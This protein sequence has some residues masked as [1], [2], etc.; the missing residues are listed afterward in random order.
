MLKIYSMPKKDLSIYKSSSS[1]TTLTKPRPMILKS[2]IKN[3]WQ[4]ITMI[5]FYKTITI[6]INQS[7]NYK[8]KT[9]R[10]FS[11]LNL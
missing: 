3:Q 7:T 6:L 2:K 10:I 9:F 11:Q 5:K 4:L 8:I 1:L